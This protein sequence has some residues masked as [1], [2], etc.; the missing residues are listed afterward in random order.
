M[1]KILRFQFLFMAA[2][3][4]TD[5]IFLPSSYAGYYVTI[6]GGENN[7]I[8]GG[9]SVISAGKSNTVRGYRSV[10]SSGNTNTVD[11]DF[12][13]I[14]GGSDNQITGWF[15]HY[16]AIAGGRSNVIS[17]PSNGDNNYSTIIGGESNTITK[18]NAVIPGGRNNTASG[19]YSLSAG[20]YM[21]ISGTGSFLWGYLSASSAPV[22]A[23]YA[24][25]IY[26]GSM[27]IRDTNPAAK[28]E[29]NRNGNEDNDYLQLTSNPAATAGDILK[30][31]SLGQIGVKRTTP[32]FLLEFG[33]GAYVSNTGNFVNASSRDYKENISSLNSSVALETFLKL[34]PVEYNYKNEPDERYLGFIAEDVPSL[35][36]DKN[37]EG[38][39]PLEIAALLTKVIAHQQ[40]ILNE[41]KTARKKL[42]EEI[43]E[44]KKRK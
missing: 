17:D 11:K 18:N 16:S 34:S 27:G 22:T 12:A 19:P 39:S 9:Y 23:N 5:N 4:L 36:A 32:G 25:M 40:D 43:K 42:F 15:G 29:I 21:N 10:I 44:L 33:N 24:M 8:E 3:V 14:S 31:N 38:L 30:I 20:R 13:V 1:K 2:L 28:L 6:S 35:V 26:N 41:Q 37:R 7:L